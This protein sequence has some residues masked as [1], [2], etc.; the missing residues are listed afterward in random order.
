MKGLRNLMNRLEHDSMIVI[1]WFE[2]DYMG[3]VGFGKVKNQKLVGVIIDK[4]LK[5]E[6]HILKQCKKAGQKLCKNFT[7]LQEFVTF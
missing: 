3:R 7:S 1:E 4:H 5:F 2:S 6:E